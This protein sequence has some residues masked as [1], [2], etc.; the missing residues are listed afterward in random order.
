MLYELLGEFNP[1]TRDDYR[2]LQPHNKTRL[3]FD[4]LTTH[5]YRRL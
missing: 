5:D 3:D 1:I 2:R 4:F